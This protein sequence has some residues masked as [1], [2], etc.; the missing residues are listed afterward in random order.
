MFCVLLYYIC[1]TCNLQIYNHFYYDFCSRTLHQPVSSY[2]NSPSPMFEIATAY[3]SRALLIVKYSIFSFSLMFPSPNTYQLL[4]AVSRSD[5]NLQCY[6][7]LRT[8]TPILQGLPQD[9][10]PL[11]KNISF[12]K[13]IFLRCKMTAELLQ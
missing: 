8:R 12:S 5:L 2:S 4:K 13:I 10:V 1:D 6:A 3:T 9:S 11:Y 7:R